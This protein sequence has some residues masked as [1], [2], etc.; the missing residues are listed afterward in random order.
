MPSTHTA[1]FQAAA[2]KAT[3]LEAVEKIS[4]GL[5]TELAQKQLNIIADAPEIRIQD[6][7]G[8]APE[9][10]ETTMAIVADGG[11]TH[12][13]A[14]TTTFAEGSETKGT[15]KFQ[16]STGATTHA[17]IVGSSGKLQLQDGGLGLKLG[18]N[19]SVTGTSKVIQEITG[20][21][22]RDSAVLKKYPEVDMTSSVK[23]GYV[24]EASSEHSS[25]T[26]PGWNAFNGVVETT[27]GADGE[28]ISGSGKYNT[29]ATNGAY[30]AHSSNAVLFQGARGEYLGIVLPRRIKVK[31]VSV[32]GRPDSGSPRTVRE[33]ILW[34]S[35]DGSTW[36]QLQT[37][38]NTLAVYA[39]TNKFNITVDATTAYSRYRLQALSM[40][41]PGNGV[42]IGELEYYGYE[43]VG[44]GD[45][46]VDTTVKSVYNAPDLTSAALYIDGKKSGSTPTDY[47]GSSITVTNNGTWDSSDNTWSL[48]GATTSNLVSADL[49]FVGD[50]PH[51]ISA[52]VKADRLNGSGLFH[53]GTAEGEGDAAS[54]VGFLDDS[55]I[56][57]GG[58]DHFFSNA[59][60][61]NVTY[62]YNG[63]GSDK[64]LYLDGRLVGTAKNE[65]S[66]GEFPSFAMTDYS[67]YGYAASASGELSAT[68]YSH[69][70][71]DKDLSNNSLWTPSGT[72]YDSSTGAANTT[73][74]T[75]NTNGVQGHWLQLD[76]PHKLKLS[77]VG[78]AASSIGTRYAKDATVFGSNDGNSWTSVGGWTDNSHASNTLKYFTMNSNSGCYKKYRLVI[79]KNGPD[80][81]LTLTEWKLFGHRENDLVRF[82]DS[83]NVRTYPHMA[84]TGP[85][86]RGYVVSASSNHSSGSF[87]NKKTTN[88][89]K[90]FD[91]DGTTF[92]H[93][94]TNGNNDHLYDG[95]DNAYGSGSI[96]NFDPS[97]INIK[98]EWIKLQFPTKKKISRVYL[99]ARS[100]L[101]SQAPEDF[102]FYGSN[103]DAAGSWTLIQAF[104]GQAPQDDG[105]SYYDITSNP[106][107]Y[108]Y[109]LMLVT[110]AV[111]TTAL[112]ISTLEYVGTEEDLDVIARV[113]DGFD[114]KVRNLRVYS[115]ALSDARAQEI[116]DAD[117]DEFGLAKSSVSVYRGHLGVG[118]DTPEAALTVM[119]EVAELDEFPPKPM[120]AAETY[121]E[122]H[123]N[124]K[125]YGSHYNANP[126]LYPPYAG[127]KRPNPTTQWNINTWNTDNASYD[128]TT[129]QVASGASLGGYAGEWLKLSLPYGVKLGGY[130]L[131]I[132]GDWD[133]Y[134]PSDWVI[135]GSNDDTTWHLIASVTAGGITAG[136]TGVPKTKD[137]VVET[138][139]YYKHLALVCSA[140][141]GVANQ[142]N[143]TGLRYFGT[144]EQG[145]ST[146][147]NGELSLTRNLTVPRIGPPLDADDTPRRDRLVAEYNTSTNPTENG[148]VKDTSGRGLDGLTYNGASYDASEKALVFDGTNDY[149][150]QNDVH[151]KTGA[152]GMYSAS[153]WVRNRASTGL[154]TVYSI[155]T[156]AQLT[157]STLYVQDAS[158]HVVFYASDLDVTYTIPKSTW[159]NIVVTHGG[160]ATST[161]T[162][163][164]I[165]GVDVG[166]AETSG[167]NYPLSTVNFPSPCNLFLGKNS[168]NT[169]Y[170][171]PMDLSN[172]KLWDTEL[173]ADDA[174]RLYDM[175]RCDEGHH[176]VNFSKTRVGIGLGDGEAPRAA[177]DVRG[178]LY[179]HG[180]V[181]QV[182]QGVKSDFTATNSLTFVDSGLEV[183][184]TPKSNSSKILISYAANIGTHTSHAFLRLVRN[185]TPI[186]IGN[187]AGTRVQCTHYVR[188]HNDQS[189]ESYCMEFLDS[190]STTSAVTYKL[191]WSVADATYTILMN[192]SWHDSSNAYY[193]RGV[194]TIT[195]KEIAQ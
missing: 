96:A 72:G 91:R 88:E 55:H 113:G 87:S 129:K 20:P 104:T 23:S 36:N 24:I 151:L 32:Y 179:A 76:M 40:N 135:V 64:K 168:D 121:M 71:F 101:E 183:T 62:T 2:L 74:S 158:L 34:G 116:F 28:W 173:S 109:I 191:Q 8:S 145:A 97:G 93:C 115:T 6:K 195:A 111:G 52:W 12:F 99:R 103:T 161:T 58:E 120:M 126:I 38:T 164:Y 60:W 31:Y 124:F 84:M 143:F 9:N 194:S 70:V 35:N 146:L 190:P 153:V 137:F 106:A 57:W 139:K 53:L 148:V 184:I 128:S 41:T 118:T 144:R 193:G 152:G 169:V 154:Q 157:T 102:S 86:Q 50:Q 79:T 14:G 59:E 134:G 178:D 186:A 123:G 138:T 189:L 80:T 63:E 69:N 22:A 112:S 66:H 54:R 4:V 39:S 98:G 174:K 19:V 3:D 83:V 166:L 90:P 108:K 85:A 89:G 5:E 165:N 26:Y 130:Q 81:A 162:K 21:H 47:G 147:H 7:I 67:Q 65:D 188:H 170:G 110:K 119:D 15:I 30:L 82:P 187:A 44:A 181:V 56:S 61:H 105:T 43:D 182:V 159:T 140:V 107:H 77:Y 127:F 18:S 180:S 155:G 46:S 78:V 94:E 42:S 27:N 11:T 17:E 185:G 172:F 136:Q 149:V 68:D 132:R 49:G 25:G 150:F 92:W 167:T 122:G 117:K 51:S 142:L 141:H 176:V 163:M 131:M 114:G 95:T 16:S 160:G 13:R 156:Y 192:A 33:Y 10:N 125:V 133:E 171:G 37:G 100:G 48:S 29:S 45:D 75:T 1:D 175:G 73:G 177:L